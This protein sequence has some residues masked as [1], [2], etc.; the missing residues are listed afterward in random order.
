MN[1]KA[2]MIASAVFLAVA[3]IAASIAPAELLD[4]LHA[5]PRDPLPVVV[6][7][8]GALYLA[9]AITN[10]TAKDNAIGGIYSRPLS[11]GNFLHFAVGSLALAKQQFPSRLSF[12]L[13]AVLIVYVIFAL[14]FGWLLFSPRV[15]PRAGSLQ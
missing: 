5:P 12:P 14:L 3:G 13:S 6:Q 9:F 7:L 11:L 1:P 10:W 15:A 2:L 8:L 4:A